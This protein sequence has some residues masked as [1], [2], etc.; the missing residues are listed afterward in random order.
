MKKLGLA[1]VAI[2]ILIAAGLF[3]LRGN[4]D[5]LAKDA[6]ATQGSAMTL[7]KVSVGAVEIR[8][9]DGTGIIRDLSIGN[10]AGFNTA[11]ALKV[12]EIE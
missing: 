10:P 9:S 5:G 12:G 4:L 1:A 11:H 8:G 7:A 6:I 2:L 3:W